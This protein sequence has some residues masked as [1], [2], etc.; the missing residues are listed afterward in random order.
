M[1]VLFSSL[2]GLVVTRTL[3]GEYSWSGPYNGIAVG[4]SR[5][6][7]LLATADYAAMKRLWAAAA[8]RQALQSGFAEEELSA[9]SP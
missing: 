3:D 9:L 2:Q 5:R 1:A 7:G 8:A 6:R 4:P